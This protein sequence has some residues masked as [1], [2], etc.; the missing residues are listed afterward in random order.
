M[1]TV[2]TGSTGRPTGAVVIGATGGI[3]RAFVHHL[4]GSGRFETVI[5][6]GRRSHPA[7]DLSDEASI[8]A[9]ANYI[10]D[11]NGD[12]RLV[13]DA[14][15][16]L[17]DEDFQPEKTWQQ[18]DPVH[19]AISFAVNAIGP[20]LL[21]KHFAPLLPRDGRSVF[22]TL[23]AKVGSIG[24]N[25]TGGWY[26]YRAAKA[27]LNQIVHTAAIELARKRKSAICVA[28]HPGTVD[29]GLSGPFAKAG[30]QVQ[31]PQQAVAHMMS[32]I[33]GLTPAQSGGFYAWDGTKLPW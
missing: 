11:M 13:I 12:I 24:D 32:V 26:S 18:I 16:W 19:M 6:L 31:S 29:T 7:L 10:A 22:A 20:A 8:A 28:L 1:E 15:G 30:L 23:S 14:T 17:H 21:I 25:R 4:E 27:A 2:P 33:D 5:A 9:C 3:G